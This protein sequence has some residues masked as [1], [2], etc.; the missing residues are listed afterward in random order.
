MSALGLVTVLLAGVLAVAWPVAWVTAR[1]WDHLLMRAPA[2]HGLRRARWSLVV[3][4][5]PL[6][7]GAVVVLAAAGAFEHGVAC[8][9]GPGEGV[10]LCL[11]HPAQAAAL[12][13][14]AL[15]LLASGAPRAARRALSLLR[16]WRLSQRLARV[17]SLAQPDR[18]CASRRWAAPTPSP[19]ACGAPSRW[20][21]PTGGAP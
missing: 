2:E 6:A 17:A 7:L 1:V 3:L 8:H 21:T 18:A 13:P 4:A 5:A 10:H 11:V 16:G 15:L 12:V 20:S 19:W 14:W 9:C